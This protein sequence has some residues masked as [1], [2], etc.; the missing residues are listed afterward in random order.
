MPPLP[1]LGY[2]LDRGPA[3]P[4][5]DDWFWVLYD[6][7]EEPWRERLCLECPPP[8]AG[9]HA[10]PWVLTPDGDI[11]EEYLED[12]LNVVTGDK[13]RRL[14]ATLGGGHGQPVYRFTRTPTALQI[15][16]A[17]KVVQEE[18]LVRRQA[19]TPGRAPRLIGKQAVELPAIEDV[20]QEGGRS[21][22][23]GRSGQG[24]G[25]LGSSE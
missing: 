10:L 9:D 2:N 25:V 3:L 16:R 13:A 24:M 1:V 8:A 12:M 20:P 18:L 15:D 22:F 19:A 5:A 4:V 14:P 11:Y 7:A 17:K 6:E 21:D 23:M